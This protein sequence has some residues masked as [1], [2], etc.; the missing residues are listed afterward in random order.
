MGTPSSSPS[1]S[2]SASVS[3]SASVT[4]SPSPSVARGDT[5]VIDLEQAKDTLHVSGTDHDARIDALIDAA[6]EFVQERQRRKL[7]N[8]TCIDYLDDWPADGVLRPKYAPLVSVTSIQYVDTDGVLQ[9]WDSDEYD[10]DTDTEP[11]RIVEAYGESFPSLRGD[12][13]GVKVTYVA[14]YGTDPDDVPQRTRN[15]I[16]LLVYDWFYHPDREDSLPASVRSLMD[17]DA[18]GLV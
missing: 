8:T 6:T 10:V 7:L 11:G 13:N 3:T 17:F 5:Q 2:V 14:G 15:G 4:P 12:I 9:T 1:S 18:L 16:L